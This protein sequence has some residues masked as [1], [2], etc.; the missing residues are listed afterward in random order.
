M[1]TFDTNVLIYST[2]P[3]RISKS[4]RAREIVWRGGHRG[5]GIL[6]LQALAEFS[7]V[8][9]RK[10]GLPIDDVRKMIDAWRSVLTVRAADD[11]DLSAA[12]EVVKQHKFQFWD[13]LLWAT[14]HRVGVRHIL[15]EDF[16]DGRVLD[17]VMFINPFNPDNDPII[18]RVLPA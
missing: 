8:T 13:A 10:V 7:N 6:L 11:A 16:Q 3:A 4:E 18:D 5:T 2:A 1:I 9:V 12:L 17:G 14:A 15:T